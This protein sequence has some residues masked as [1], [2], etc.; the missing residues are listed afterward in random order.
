LD[1][2]AARF[3]VGWAQEVPSDA[4]L[5]LLVHLDRPAGLPAEPVMLRD[6]IRQFFGERSA[7][8]KR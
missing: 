4:P 5:A 1:P 8:S 3:I 6:A 2:A 7:E